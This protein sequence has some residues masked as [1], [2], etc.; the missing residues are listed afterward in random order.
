[1]A[2]IDELV[3]ILG[4]KLDPNATRQAG[5]LKSALGGIVGAA[6]AVG[7][8]LA[9]A[10][11]AVQAYA[12]HQA[13]AIADTKRLADMLDVSFERLQELG[14]AASATGGSAQELQNDLEH[15][16]KTMSSPIPGEYNQT[17]YML[18][19]SARNASGQLK[20]A[21]EVLLEIAGKL[22]GMSKQRQ[23]QMADRLGLSKTSLRLIQEGR[24]GIE[25][26]AGQARELGIVL[27]KETGAKAVEFQKTMAQVRATLNGIGTTITAA[28]LP[29]LQAGAKWLA[30]WIKSN[31]ELIAS[32]IAQ[33]VDGV[34]QGFQLFGKAI[35]LV[36]SAIQK[37]LGPLISLP[38]AFNAVQVIAVAVA[39]GLGAMAAAAI[40]AIAPFAAI[41]AGITALVFVIEDLYTYLKGGDSL[42]G[43]WVDAFKKAYPDL[44]AFIGA[45]VSLLGKL[46]ELLAGRLLS[47]AQEFLS[48]L[49]TG[50]K[51]LLGTIDL[52]L[53]G[54]DKLIAA[55]KAIP[56]F[57]GKL[58]PDFLKNGMPGLGMGGAS[59]VPP[60]IVLG[61]ASRG[62]GG[63]Q[64]GNITFNIDG[65]AS[66]MATGDEIVRRL[67]IGESMQS[68][69]PGAF[70]P[71]VG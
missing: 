5:L 20:S 43:E 15:L 14:Y 66:P 16:T 11:A 56:D 26:L 60:G 57:A 45:A 13:D 59:P 37:L 34:A 48:V 52:I 17:L 4:L 25:A 35:Q 69:A 53:S 70:G 38:K 63:G 51:I 7:T 42:I 33:F 22:Q 8:A 71:T 50:F 62:A 24:A 58:V 49:N 1:M 68:V 18:G 23:L 10:G 47:S 12:L 40:S 31:R 55:A 46:A 29:S 36:W 32:G 61:A 2:V 39:I 67:G 6:A 28:L 41:V 54:A 44:A 19:I 21:D 30:E 3:T 9:A 65:T 64:Q 27:D